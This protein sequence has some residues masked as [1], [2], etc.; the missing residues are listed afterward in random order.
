MRQEKAII[1]PV[2]NPGIARITTLGHVK[3]KAFFHLHCNHFKVKC[4]NNA[5]VAYIL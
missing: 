5:Q 3:L 2:V 4:N 1:L